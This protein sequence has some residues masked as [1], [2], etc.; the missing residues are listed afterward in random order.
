[1]LLACGTRGREHIF[2]IAKRWSGGATGTREFCEFFDFECCLLIARRELYL[3]N[4]HPAST[5]FL[6]R[7][8][9]GLG[10]ADRRVA[11]ASVNHDPDQHAGSRGSKGN[12]FRIHGASCAGGFPA[13]A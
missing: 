3:N 7:S 6:P 10:C 1:M 9:L 5:I 4:D 11:A 8:A 12:P 2:G 13:V